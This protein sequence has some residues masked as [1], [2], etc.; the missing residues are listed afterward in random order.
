MGTWVAELFSNEVAQRIGWALIHFL[1]QGL[2]V[3]V[4]LMLTLQLLRRRSAQARWLVSCAALGL[5][6]VLPVVTA[7]VVTVDPAPTGEAASVIEAPPLSA[8]TEFSRTSSAVDVSPLPIAAT[9]PVEA[10]A[11]MPPPL[12]PPAAP[13][14][15]G[16]P[17]WYEQAAV[18]ITPALPWFLTIWLMGVLALSLWQVGGWLQLE[19]LKRLDTQPVTGPIGDLFMRLRKRLSVSRPV[20]LLKSARVAAPIV[21]GWLKPVVLLPACALSGLTTEQLEAVL[22]HELAHVRRYDC[23]VRLLQVVVETLLFYHPAVWWVS[24]RITEEG[25][26]CCDELAVAHCG[27]RHGYASALARVAELSRRQPRLAVAAAGGRLGTRIRR[28]LGRSEGDRGARPGWLVLALAALVVAGLIVY[29]CLGDGVRAEVAS[30]WAKARGWTASSVSETSLESRWGG[31][32]NLPFEI[33]KGEEADARRCVKLARKFP[34]SMNG[35]STFYDDST[36]EALEKLLVARPGYFYAEYLLGQ[37]HRGKGNARQAD[38]LREKAY[39]HAPVII[40]Q[41]YV[42]DKNIAL[43]GAEIQ[44]FALECNRVKNGYL[45]PSLELHYFNLRTDASGCIYLPA[46]NTVFRRETASWPTGYDADYP[47]LGWFETSTRVGQLP[48]CVVT[49]KT[50]AHASR[51]KELLPQLHLERDWKPAVKELIEIGP[52]V[53]PAMLPLLDRGGTDTPAIRVLRGLADDPG[54]QQ[55]MLD[56]LDQPPLRKMGRRYAAILVLGKSGDERHVPRILE[57]LRQAAGLDPG[58]AGGEIG[59]LIALSEIGGDAGYKALVEATRIAS[60]QYRYLAAQY[61]ARTGRLEALPHLRRVLQGIDP[62]HPNHA[63]RNI[64][65]AI[66]DLEGRFGREEIASQA[67]LRRMMV[68]AVAARLSGDNADGPRQFSRPYERRVQDLDEYMSQPI[69]CKVIELNRSRNNVVLSRR[70]VLEEERKEARQQILDRLEKGE[71]VEGMISN[72]VD[73]GAFVDLDGIDGLIH[74]SELSWGHVNHP[75]EVLSIGDTVK[76]KVL[77]IDRDRQ[78]ISLGLKQTQEDPW[79][80][81]ISAYDI[82]DVLEGKVTKVVN[83]GAFVEIM[84]GVEGL[85]HISEL[86]Q[87]HVENPREVVNPGD[88]VK[89]KILEIDDERRRL[90]LSLK[91]VEGQALPI[92]TSMPTDEEVAA[93]GE[94][95]SGE[96]ADAAAETSEDS[97]LSPEQQGVAEAEAAIEDAVVEEVAEQAVAEDVA[98]EGVAAEDAVEQT[99]EEPAPEE[100]APEEQT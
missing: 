5:M 46:Y 1:W 45:D 14:D 90:S 28:I 89:V 98:G 87:H 60:P 19:R 52:E 40:V 9:A 76:V 51:I 97:A 8:T 94:G 65:T 23:L 6:A 80:R 20:R 48:I 4:L 44:S 37:W 3:T 73:F 29:D 69:E 81:V 91:R 95:E 36:R 77:E 86:A 53:A 10:A 72:I 64:I 18:W 35:K 15:T 63:A 43:A 22:A 49:P 84:E 2:A 100:P 71:V 66:T 38:E 57:A 24:R 16:S 70:A 59:P 61:L 54:V 67:A 83:F 27:D 33:S 55:L 82:N 85:V 56:I 34:L 26:H 75:S 17:P 7:C 74:I 39:K 41:P 68:A 58:T 99:P 25:E 62:S 12:D 93:A 96:T 88:D 32:R 47:R 31:W 13:R 30:R 21:V 78:R 42:D 79:Q 50:E 11:P 92:H